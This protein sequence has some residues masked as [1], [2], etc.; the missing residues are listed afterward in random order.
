M[1][2][3]IKKQKVNAFFDRSEIVVEAS[4]TATPSYASIKAEVA[5]KMKVGED[6]VVVKRVD[7][8]FGKQVVLAN[9][10]VYSS[11]EALKKYEMV[12]IKKSARAAAAA[13]AIKK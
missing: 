12:I 2:I 3:S 9:V 1:E 5:K 4:D 13:N 6:V 7:Q 10:H 8:Q 11:P